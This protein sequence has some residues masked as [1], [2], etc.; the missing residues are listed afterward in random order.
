VETGKKEDEGCWIAANCLRNSRQCDLCS[1]REVAAQVGYRPTI[2]KTK[3]R[4]L[5]PPFEDVGDNR[6]ARK[7]ERLCTRQK[8]NL[9]FISSVLTHA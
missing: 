1:S 8:L 7:S 2:D 5:D 9:T 6:R 3:E 4:E